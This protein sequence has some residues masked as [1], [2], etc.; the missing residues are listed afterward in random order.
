M[1]YNSRADSYFTDLISSE[2]SMFGIT[3]EVKSLII[4]S[5]LNP[6]ALRK[7]KIIYNFGLSEVNRV[8]NTIYL[9]FLRL[10]GGG[11]GGWKRSG[12]SLPKQ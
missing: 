12:G 6:I 10:W 11:G 8:K 1:M 5:C 3:V 9:C 2:H 4:Q 7:T